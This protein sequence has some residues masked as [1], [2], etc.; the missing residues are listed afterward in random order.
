MNKIFLV[1]TLSIAFTLSF[2]KVSQA[3]ETFEENFYKKLEYKLLIQK[4]DLKNFPDI[5]VSVTP[6]D[7]NKRSILVPKEQIKNLFY[8]KENHK[9]ISDFSVEVPKTNNTVL[10][11]CFVI[12]DSYLME[13]NIT[14]IKKIVTSLSKNLILMIMFQL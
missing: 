6:Q 9:N 12:D 8:I 1:F 14:K 7:N 4:I 2:F 11:I 5:S 13:N 3:E 10:S